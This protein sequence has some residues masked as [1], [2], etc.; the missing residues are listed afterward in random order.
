LGFE[1]PQYFSK[2]AVFLSNFQPT[3][4]VLNF[5][6]LSGLVARGESHRSVG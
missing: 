4:C 1:Y 3:K 6:I 5:L 2:R